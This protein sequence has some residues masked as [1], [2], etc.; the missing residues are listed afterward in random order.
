MIL[1]LA[2]PP[3]GMLRGFAASG[4]TRSSSERAVP[5]VSSGAST[6][7]RTTC[8]HGPKVG[9]PGVSE[10]IR[11][12][13]I[14]GR[15]LEHSRIYAFQRGEET[16]VLTG[17]ADLMPRNLDSRVELVTPIE[18]EGLKAELLDALE[19]SFAENGNAWELGTDGAWTRL[20]AP[21]GDGRTV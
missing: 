7:A 21:A 10:S 1:G 6:I 15:F 20:N 13:S 17:S 5:I 14:V 12:V 11:V 16:R 2:P 4:T 18:D 3:I 19:R 9:V 8:R